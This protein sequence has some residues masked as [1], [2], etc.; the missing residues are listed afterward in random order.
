MSRRTGW[1]DNQ[2]H[3]NI[4][5]WGV[6][7]KSSRFIVV[8][9]SDGASQARVQWPWDDVAGKTLH[10]KDAFSGAAYD[11]DGSEIAGEGLYVDLKPWAFHYLNF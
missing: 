1:P 4:V 5:A 3:L 2:S 11:R 7:G 6:R 9:L 8:N 10:L